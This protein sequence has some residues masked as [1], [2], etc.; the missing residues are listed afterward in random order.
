MSVGERLRPRGAYGSI[1]VNR[2]VSVA[3]VSWIVCLAGCA[4]TPE[5]PVAADQ[6]IGPPSEPTAF[7]WKLDGPDGAAYLQACS[8]GVKR[9]LHLQEAPGGEFDLWI[10]LGEVEPAQVR[11][12]LIMLDGVGY[13]LLRELYE[14]GHFRL[15]YPPSRMVAPFPSLTDISFNNMLGV[16]GASCYEAVVFNRQRN[17]LYS[18]HALYL[19]GDNELWAS[20]LDYRQDMWVDAVSYTMSDYATRREFH[21]MFETIDEVLDERP[22]QRDVLVYSVSTDAAAHLVGHDRMAELMLIL[23]RYIERVMYDRAGRVGFVLLSDHGNNLI[24]DCRRVDVEGAMK[25]V[26]LKPVF[27]RG[28][29]RPGDVVVPQYGLISFARMFC[30]NDQDRDTLIGALLEAEGVEHVMWMQSDRAMVAGRDGRAAIGY[31][32]VEG[33]DGSAE[34][35][36][37]YVPLEGDPLALADLLTDLRGRKFE[38]DEAAW[39]SASDL[40]EATGDHDWPDPLWRIWH[41]LT[42]QVAVAPDVAVSLAP[43]WY[44]GSPG[45]DWFA[46][47]NGTHGGLRRDDSIT[48]FTTTMFP[49]PPLMRTT[50]VID[51]VNRHFRWTPPTADPSEFGLHEYLGNDR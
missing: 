2:I 19:S 33:E 15:F 28:F 14:K 6:I 23:E 48:F 36:Y 41:G 43:G 13:K 1:S 31:R 50:D 30:Q 27:D 39:Y 21:S 17:K 9:A 47:L 8:A 34:G 4:G 16:S 38:G 10:D 45:L 7:I 11:H 5:W 42:D 3:A 12:V 51:V 40:L 29:K 18:G 46:G 37:S 25:A 20:R 22:H 35:Y 24:P 26:G 49:G 44:Y 32:A